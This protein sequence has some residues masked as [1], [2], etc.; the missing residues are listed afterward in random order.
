[1]RLKNLQIG[2]AL[3]KSVTSM[4]KIQ[5]ARFYV[6]GDNLLTFSDITGVFDPELLGGD[7]GEGKL[8]PLSKVISVGVNINF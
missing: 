5:R 8:Y 7:W 3:P 1:M 6:S 2:Y 4:L